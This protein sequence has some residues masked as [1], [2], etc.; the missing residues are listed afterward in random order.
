MM[1]LLEA[2]CKN[3]VLSSNQTSTK[4]VSRNTWDVQVQ[5]SPVQLQRRRNARFATN[6]PCTYPA[7]G[8]KA[9]WL[10]GELPEMLAL[11]L[12]HIHS[13]FY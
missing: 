9:C 10:S 7:S 5:R 11:T 8:L 1:H 3:S 12:T 6:P 4:Q 13:T 2:Y